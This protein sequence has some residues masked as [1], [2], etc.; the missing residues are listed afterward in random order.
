MKEDYFNI[1][2]ELPPIDLISYEN[3]KM[4]LDI[5]DDFDTNEVKLTAKDRIVM[6][7]VYLPITVE[8]NRK[9]N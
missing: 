6:V 2:S 4:A 1:V 7:T 9:T 3:N 5:Y 8:K